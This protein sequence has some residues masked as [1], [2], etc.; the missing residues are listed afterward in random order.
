MT[1]ISSEKTFLDESCTVYVRNPYGTPINS[2]PSRGHTSSLTQ[3]PPS[4]RIQLYEMPE[5]FLHNNLSSATSRSLNDRV[6]SP[7]RIIPHINQVA[8]PFIPYPAQRP[9]VSTLFEAVNDTT[10]TMS[11]LRGLTRCQNPD[12]VSDIAKNYVRRWI[13][14]LKQEKNPDTLRHLLLEAERGIDELLSFPLRN[15]VPVKYRG[16]LRDIIYEYK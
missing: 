11:Q 5:N 4:E 7:P 10:E 9:P 8:I 2:A 14:R 16:W 13:K 3:N 1:I 12:T 6:S 15:L